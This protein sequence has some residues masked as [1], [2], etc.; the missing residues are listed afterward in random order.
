M[1]SGQINLGL[2]MESL[3]TSEMIYD[4]KKNE[5][6]ELKI[7]QIEFESDTWKRLLNF[8]IDENIHLKKML[9]EVLKCRVDKNLLEQIEDFHN[10]L[11]KQDEF[12]GLLR[13]EIAE[14]DKFSISEIINDQKIADEATRKLKNLRYGMMNAERH[15]SKL[16]SEFNNFLL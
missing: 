6:P 8:I 2:N 16:K 3:F 7:K 15:F 12:I 9:S 13:N 14:F 5:L 4:G 1:N 11:L 10:K